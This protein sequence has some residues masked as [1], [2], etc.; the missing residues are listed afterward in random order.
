MHSILQGHIT[1]VGLSLVDSEGHA[2]AG[3]E[4]N[5]YQAY[6]QKT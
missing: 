3:D 4:E 5:L 1:N 6:L 2:L